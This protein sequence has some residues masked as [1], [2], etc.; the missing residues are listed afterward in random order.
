M[1]VLDNFHKSNQGTL[2]VELKII[3]KKRII[4]IIIII[5]II[6]TIIIIIII[7]M[8]ML[9]KLGSKHFQILILN[10]KWGV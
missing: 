2:G 5:V 7:I 8:F 10:K 9:E 6:I 3:T 4:I 1:G